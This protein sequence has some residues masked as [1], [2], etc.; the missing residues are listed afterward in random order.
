MGS[1][2]RNMPGDTYV[3]NRGE[4]HYF[5]LGG[6]LEIVGSDSC[7]LHRGKLRPERRPFPG[8]ITGPVAGLARHLGHCFLP[9]ASVGVCSLRGF[10]ECSLC[11]GTLHIVSCQILSTVRVVGI[12]TPL[13]DE[14][15]EPRNG[16]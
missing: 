4:L 13:T 12:T 11:P 16:K 15:T 8:T 3:L 14:E 10:L 1:V 2:S 9:G 6:P 5:K 7:F